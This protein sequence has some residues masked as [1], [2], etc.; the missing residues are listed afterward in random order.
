MKPASTPT[1]TR[2]RIDENRRNKRHGHPVTRIAAGS[3]P[4]GS[5]VVRRSRCK[6]DGC[7]KARPQSCFCFHS[8]RRQ[9]SN[10][11][12]DAMMPGPVTSRYRLRIPGCSDPG[13][14]SKGSRHER[15]LDTHSCLNLSRRH[16]HD[17]SFVSGEHHGSH[18][19]IRHDRHGL[20]PRSLAGY[21]AIVRFGFGS[22]PRRDRPQV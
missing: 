2:E 16:R 13:L 17:R 10:G 9:A 7:L 11:R 19:E 6:R 12:L 18:K 1:F 8:Q 15:V 20:S 4:S 3:S 22:G 21:G 14:S 5:S